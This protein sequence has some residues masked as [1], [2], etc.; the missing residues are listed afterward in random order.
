VTAKLEVYRELADDLLDRHGAGARWLDL[1]C[2]NGRFM[3]LLRAWGWRVEGVDR[4]PRAV[5]ACTTRGLPAVVGAVPEY[6][7]G[8]SGE[9]FAAISLIQVIEHLPT[10]TWLQTIRAAE[11]SL[12]PGGALLIETIDPRNPEA[13]QA[14]FADVT[15]TWA[16][17]PET[18]R[19]MCE[20]AGFR[21]VEVRGL[22]PGDDGRPQDFAL[23]ARK[24]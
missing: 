12:A 15:H 8:S 7:S 2:G 19:V 23:L 22:N 1:G 20:F 13:L 16:A 4:S 21:A 5:E 18:L 17:H 9:T 6:L 11:R 3:E 10:A 24:G 14:F